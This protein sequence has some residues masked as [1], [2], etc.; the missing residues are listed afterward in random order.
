MNKYNAHKTV[1]DNITFDSKKEA[2]R[3]AELKMCMLARGNDKVV[4]LELQPKYPC[5]VNG[6]KVCTYIAD[7][8]IEYAD[9]TV[10]VE[11]VKGMRTPI[12]RLKKKLVEALYGIEIVET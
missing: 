12:Y 5:V 7:F 3:Y 8:K 1:V 11:D 9:G 10:V 6:K 2:N 4:N